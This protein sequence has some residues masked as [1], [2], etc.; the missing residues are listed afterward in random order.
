MIGII[1]KDKSG[2]TML[3]DNEIMYEV[4]MCGDYEMIRIEPVTGIL[5]VNEIK[6]ITHTFLMPISKK[7]P[8]LV[9]RINRKLTR[10]A[11]SATRLVLAI[12]RNPKYPIHLL[13]D[14]IGE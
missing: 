8:L 9:T 14:G 4:M 6:D 1:L 5:P 2:S 3:G 10:L 7:E 11:S 12:N 13:F